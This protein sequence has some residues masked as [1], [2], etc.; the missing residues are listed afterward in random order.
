MASNR[1][2]PLLEAAVTNRRYAREGQ[3]RPEQAPN[4]WG[5]FLPG[6]LQT[7]IFRKSTWR[8]DGFGWRYF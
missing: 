4:A 7:A 2:F 3:R 1:N 6:R 8:R 5:I